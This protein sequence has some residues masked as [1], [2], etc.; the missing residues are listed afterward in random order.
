MCHPHLVLFCSLCTFPQTP[1]DIP[2]Y[3]VTFSSKCCHQFGPVA[4]CH[5]LNRA[6]KYTALSETQISQCPA[7]RKVLSLGVCNMQKHILKEKKSGIAYLK[8][9]IFS[10]L[11]MHSFNST[12]VQTTKYFRTGVNPELVPVS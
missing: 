5:D 9:I 8:N 4:L 10:I 12:D 1:K 11:P 6:P 7:I 3:R 2:I